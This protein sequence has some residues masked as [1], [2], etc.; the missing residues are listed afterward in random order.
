MNLKQ[1]NDQR[2]YYSHT[3]R[4]NFVKIGM[5]DVEKIGLTEIV[6]KETAAEH[7]SVV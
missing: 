3:D 2:H 5:V 7:K 1:V 4:T 6:K